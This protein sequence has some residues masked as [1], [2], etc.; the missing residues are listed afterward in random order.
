MV[1]TKKRSGLKG[2]L[3]DERGIENNLSRFKVHEGSKRAL[4]KDGKNDNQTN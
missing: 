1:Y 3:E 4:G 2:K